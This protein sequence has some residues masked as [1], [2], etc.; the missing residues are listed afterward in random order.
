[1]TGD[2]VAII[3]KA[4]RDVDIQ[5]KVTLES[6]GVQR[7]AMKAVHGLN[8]KREWKNYRASVTKRYYNLLEK[9]HVLT[10]LRNNPA[11]TFYGQTEIIGV[12]NSDGKMITR[13]KGKKN[14]FRIADWSEWAGTEANR[15]A[16]LGDLK[17]TSAIESNIRKYKTGGIVGEFR[18]GSTISDQLNKERNALLRAKKLKGLLMLR[19]QDVLTGKYHLEFIDPKN[20]KPSIIVRYGHVHESTLPRSLPTPPIISGGDN[21]KQ[22][23]RGK[24]KQKQPASRTVYAGN[25]PRGKGR[26]KPAIEP[27]RIARVG[28]PPQY[29]FEN[30]FLKRPSASSRWVDLRPKHPPKSTASIEQSVRGKAG[31]GGLKGRRSV[32]LGRG[33]VRGVGS[34]G[35]LFADI[36]WQMYLQRQMEKWNKI[37]AKLDREYSKNESRRVQSAI[38]RQQKFMNKLL[39]RKNKEMQA[40]TNAG[41]PV[42][43]NITVELEFQ[44][45]N[46]HKMFFRH[47]NNSP[48]RWRFDYISRIDIEISDVESPTSMDVIKR[49]PG[50]FPGPSVSGKDKSLQRLKYSVNVFRGMTEQERKLSNRLGAPVFI[51]TPYNDQGQPSLPITK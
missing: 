19:V 15:V 17:T 40:L 8:W 24:Q 13:F 2:R 26:S 32:R 43:V 30:P 4:M 22:S 44:D 33:T 36:V 14:K 39:K 48:F 38:Q 18:P 11:R 3:A 35:L 1:M 47:N 12:V 10:L 5:L 45:E 25:K 31:V 20:L 21:E 42:V 7:S 23:A 29:K 34:G 49:G 27:T 6:I 51:D 28:A 46:K 37:G 41:K 50:F 16:Q 9:K